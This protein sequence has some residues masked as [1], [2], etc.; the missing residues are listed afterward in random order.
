MKL[1]DMTG[2]CGMLVE[3][4]VW[5]RGHSFACLRRKRGAIRYWVPEPSIEV[6]LE[7][8]CAFCPQNPVNVA[9]EIPRKEIGETKL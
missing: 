7:N 8:Y 1:P 6:E 4:K 2:K 9:L 3:A 5:K